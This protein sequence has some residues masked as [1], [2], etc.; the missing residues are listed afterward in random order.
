[1]GQCR[2]GNAAVMFL[3][4][5]LLYMTSCRNGGAA[6]CEAAMQLSNSSTAVP[7][8]QLQA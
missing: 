2:S 4:H 3:N 5:L 7:R 1:M 8:V 6:C